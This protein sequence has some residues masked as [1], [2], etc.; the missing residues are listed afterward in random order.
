MMGL[1]RYDTDRMSLFEYQA[2]MHHW[3]AAHSRDK[4]EGGKGEHKVPHERTE[5]LIATLNANPELL[6]P[7]PPGFGAP[8]P[9]NIKPA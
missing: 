1:G 6:G 8:D 5:E 9:A 7:A 4:G 2:R 3:N